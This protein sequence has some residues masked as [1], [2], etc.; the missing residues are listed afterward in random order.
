MNLTPTF[1]AGSNAA[2][3]T[4]LIYTLAV[5]GLAAVVKPFDEK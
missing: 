1:A 4:F 5:F 2:L 3:I